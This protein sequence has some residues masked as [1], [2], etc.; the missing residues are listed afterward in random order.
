MGCRVH[1][2]LPDAFKRSAEVVLL[3]GVTL[4][5][6][7]AT[8]SAT[9]HWTMAVSPAQV[10]RGGNVAITVSRSRC[11][12]IVTVNGNRQR[13]KINRVQLLTISR[14]APTGRAKVEVD[15]GQWYETESFTITKAQLAHR[16]AVTVANVCNLDAAFGTRHVQ[17]LAGHLAIVWT[18]A[19]G[20]PIMFVTGSNGNK[21]AAVL[22]AQGGLA[23][24][25]SC[26]WS[27]WLSWAQYEQTTG[28]P[29]GVSNSATSEFGYL[30]QEQQVN[31]IQ[32]EDSDWFTPASG[33]QECSTNPYDDCDYET[34][35]G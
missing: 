10:P 4:F 34:S 2:R 24:F 17:Q 1:S 9:P 21:Y 19:A 18:N 29:Q 8:A 7:A 14:S 16:T 26:T 35:D 27:Q 22:N 30:V 15:C 25:A 11:R 31:A 32:Q 28:Q 20:R 6:F 13:Y 3:A 33:W 12:L 5:L 23:Y